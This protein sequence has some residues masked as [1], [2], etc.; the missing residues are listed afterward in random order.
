MSVWAIIPVKPLGQAK[1]RLAG[2]LSPAERAALGRQL[3]VRTLEVLAEVPAIDQTLVV[4]GDRQALS[5]ARE[6]GARPVRENGVPDLN[7]ALQRA[8]RVAQRRGAS[9]VLVLPSDLPRLTA[10]EVG[11]LLSMASEPPV[12]VLAP[13]RR[14]RGT[15][16]LLS[17]PAGLIEYAFGP[18]SF[19]RHLERARAAG[20]RV[21]T[22]TLP[23][24]GLDLD[25]PDD[26]GLLEVDSAS[27]EDPQ[28]E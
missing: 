6:H 13:D 12:V 15:N 20:V 5:L 18:D 28:P 19:T 2:V 25:D 17:A 21:E 27:A 8:T 11:R 22:C 14:S 4:S 16:A 10:A 1:S 23:G 9:A 26:L 3:L 24:L 7:R